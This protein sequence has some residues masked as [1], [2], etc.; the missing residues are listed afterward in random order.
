L[1][2]KIEKQTATKLVKIRGNQAAWISFSV[3]L[4]S[5]HYELVIVDGNNRNRT[6]PVSVDLKIVWF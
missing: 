2:E 1:R 5:L 6:Q 4:E 3:F